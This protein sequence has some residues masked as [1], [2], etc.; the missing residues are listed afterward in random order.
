M[1]NWSLRNKLLLGLLVVNLLVLIPMG[2]VLYWRVQHYTEVGINSS[3][4]PRIQQLF[5]EFQV[6]RSGPGRGDDS[7]TT[8]LVYSTR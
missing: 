8:K 1:N 5:E 3:L 7:Q 6:I 4:E 2:A